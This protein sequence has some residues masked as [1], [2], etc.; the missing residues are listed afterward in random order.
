[1]LIGGRERR[2]IVLV[3]H[4]PCWTRR[5][6]IERDRIRA[7][8]SGAALDV[9]HIGST[10]VPGLAAKPIVDLLVVV[11]NASDPAVTARLE[12]AGYVLRVREPRHRMLR[13]PQLDVHVHLWSAG[14]PEIARHLRFRDRLRASAA[15]RI[16]Y[17]DLKR[18]LAQRDW[19]DMNDYAAAKSALIAEILD[20]TGGS[21]SG[22]EGRSV[23]SRIDA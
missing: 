19:E 4:D 3:A 7:A 6:E 2:A 23:R 15:D 18:R 8:L 17:E 20:R 10:A 16:A 11:P 21:G 22:A 12:D 14:D 9:Q 1:V 13:T 5:F